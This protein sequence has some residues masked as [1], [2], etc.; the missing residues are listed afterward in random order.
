VI[1]RMVSMAIVTVLLSANVCGQEAQWLQY[2][3]A[4]EPHTQLPI[5]GRLRIEPTS[6][7]PKNV[8]LPTLS[9]KEPLFARWETPMAPAGH[10][11]LAMDRSSE[12]T[13]YDRLFIDTDADGSLADEQP[14]EA[15]RARVRESLSG[16]ILYGDFGPVQILFPG[17]DGPVASHVVLSLYARPGYRRLY[18]V[19]AGW[20]EGI[21]TLGGRKVHCTLIDTS[22]NG[23]FNDTAAARAACDAIRLVAEGKNRMGPSRDFDPAMHFVGRHVEYDGR[24]YR[25][26]ITPDG[27]QVTF[28]P[29]GDVPMGAVRVADDMARL[30]VFG[31]EGSFLREPAG[32][33]ATV[34][35]GTYGVH[36]WERQRKDP[37]DN[38]GWSLVEAGATKEEP[39]VV[40]ANKTLDLGIGRDVAG[41]LEVTSRSQST[42]SIGMKLMTG[43]GDYIRLLRAGQRAPRP[44]VHITNADGTCK[45]TY[46]LEYG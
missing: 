12:D 6:E 21:V 4:R 24:L 36:Q 32:G 17:E 14:I 31:P 7:A 22:V 19:S 16:R 39:F 18:V 5:V 2:R 23:R 33:V 26:T 34:P 10:V 28:A 13:S 38:V 25:L 43:K 40:E 20:Y 45:Q 41:R 3:W 44:K 37:D 8:D 1:R 9:A 15:F 30:S 29:A 42:Y 35:A 11:W 27:S 46:N